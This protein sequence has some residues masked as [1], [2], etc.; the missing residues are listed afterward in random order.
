MSLPLHDL[1]RRNTVSNMHPGVRVLEPLTVSL[2]SRVRAQHGLVSPW[3]VD[4]FDAI[5]KILG[6]EILPVV[7][8]R[9]KVQ[10]VAFEV[11]LAVHLRVMLVLVGIGPGKK[12]IEKYEPCCLTRF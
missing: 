10:V 7:G 3:Q 1:E 6:L 8:S 12:C 11:L 2:E 4:R 9:F 5:V